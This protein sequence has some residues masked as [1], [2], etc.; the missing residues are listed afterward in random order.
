MQGIQICNPKQKAKAQ[1]SRLL[2]LCVV[3]LDDPLRLADDFLL[4][5]LEL[6]ALLLL[7]LALH[8]LHREKFTRQGPLG[9]VCGHGYR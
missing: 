1:N 8:E 4:L 7:L 9:G 5:L 3:V 2:K 6:L